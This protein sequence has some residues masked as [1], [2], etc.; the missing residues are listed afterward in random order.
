MCLPLPECKLYFKKEILKAAIFRVK[1]FDDMY[2]NKT[3]P[4]KIS[5]ISVRVNLATHKQIKP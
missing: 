1:D 3:F 4:E 5:F 2:F